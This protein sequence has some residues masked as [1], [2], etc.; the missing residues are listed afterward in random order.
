MEWLVVLAIFSLVWVLG[1]YF[2]ISRKRISAGGHRYH[3]TPIVPIVL[4]FMFFWATVPG[5][6]FS[7][8]DIF[9]GGGSSG[10]T[11]GE[12]ECPI[13]LTVGG[14]KA[15]KQEPDKYYKFLLSASQDISIDITNHD[16]PGILTDAHDLTIKLH[17]MNGDG[18]CKTSETIDQKT[19]KAEN[20]SL[21]HSALSGGKFYCIEMD[22]YSGGTVRPADQF[23]IQVNG[24]AAL[25]IG[26]SDASAREDES[27]LKFVV[28]MTKASGMNV[29]FQ[30]HFEDETAVAGINYDPKAIGQSHDCTQDNPCT[31][32]IPAGEL[33]TEIE[34]PLFD[35][36]MKTS[37]TFKM[38][39]DSADVDISGDDATATG[40]I[41]GSE[42]ESG[43]DDEC[44]ENGKPCICYDS[45]E[46]SGFCMFG[47]CIFYKEQTNI[48]ALGN[49]ED[50][51][52]I[53]A[54]TRGWAFMDFLSQ[55][56]INGERK[57]IRV[58]SDQAEKRTLFDK[59]N[60][61]TDG[62]VDFID[63][64]YFLASF[65]PTGIIYRLGEGADNSDGGS[66]NAG[67]TTSYYDKSFM[68]LGLFTAYTHIVSYTKNGKTYQS[69][70][71]P[72]N[73]DTRQLPPHPEPNQCGIFLGPLNSHNKVVFKS[74][75]WQE[76]QASMLNTP[77]VEDTQNTS[78]CNGVTPCPADG[79]GSSEMDLPEFLISQSGE[80]ITIPTSTVIGG[81]IDIGAINITH[82]DD[83]NST[84]RHFVFEAPY[85]DSYGGKV[86]LI[87][88]IEDKDEQ[89]AKHVYVFK[90]GDYWI[91]DWQILG[92][93]SVTIKVPDKN[94]RVRLFIK[95]SM[96]IDITGALNIGQEADETRSPTAETTK[97]FVYLYDNLTMMAHGSKALYYTFIYSK[98]NI[99]IGIP[100]EMEDGDGSI[101]TKYSA[102]T[103]DGQLSIGVDGAGTYTPVPDTL[104]FSDLFEKC[105]E[106]GNYLTGPFD[107]WDTFRDD[108]SAPPSDRNISTKIV[109]KDFKISVAS[110]NKNNDAYKTKMGSAG[111]VEVG[112]YAN[113]S[114]T[115]EGSTFPFDA[116][117]TPHISNFPTVGGFNV[118]R[119]IKNVRVGFKLCASYDYNSTIGDKIYY[120]YPK[121][122]CMGVIHDCNFTSAGPVW[123]I[124]YAGDNFAIRPDK[125]DSNL[126]NSGF[127][128]E[129]NISIIFKALD[130]NIT[131]TKPTKN[132]NETQG[133]TFVVDFNLSDPSLDCQQKINQLTPNIIFSDGQVE[134][135]YRFKYI[136]DYNLTIREKSECNQ[137]FAAVDCDD[138][139]ISGHW[140]TD[141]NLSIEPFRLNHISIKP[142]RFVIT[143]IAYTDYDVTNHFTYISNLNESDTMAAI[144]R[145]NLDVA[146]DNG[147]TAKNY[148]D[149]CYAKDFNTTLAFVKSKSNDL[150]LQMFN[151]L[152]N[153][154]SIGNHR[155]FNASYFPKSGYGTTT[156]T[157]FINFD[158]NASKPIDVFEHN[159]TLIKIEDDNGLS[160]EASTHQSTHFYYGRL[161][162]PD[163]KTY[164]NSIVTPIYAEIYSTTSPG[165][166]WNE[167]VDDINWWINP[168]HQ[169]SDGN[170]T[171]LMPKIGFSNQDDI[172]ITPTI[173]N[174]S[175]GISNPSITYNGSDRPHK[176]QIRIGT[177]PWLR[178]HRFITD[179]NKML[180][181]N[182]EFLGRGGW[183]GVGQKGQTLPDINGTNERIEW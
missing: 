30:Y 64:S 171:A 89:S 80:D 38:I 183:A 155:D 134:G 59:Y 28:A 7:F 138:A 101:A 45:R 103:A 142:A 72:C 176:T 104:R 29:N 151:D 69:V 146:K 67:D 136:G 5:Y 141:E 93:K 164:D 147:D 161:H 114:T 35:T 3:L 117:A 180:Y 110:L 4:V 47:S 43:S 130:G 167:S 10:C 70:L 53:K 112:I 26:V 13:E 12:A 6:A 75:S 65:L 20:F 46:T 74:R 42:S 129:R 57:T 106:S 140:N 126:T 34:V 111:S 175:H 22:G 44:G 109:G 41:I 39:I 36:H 150:T 168:L 24:S 166:D 23:D 157:L 131:S 81:Q 178:Y 163:Y 162:A 55:I 156:L 113:G 90:D 123:R 128:A 8:G 84:I 98:D 182:V 148:T 62:Q 56:G 71:Q 152:N 50:V 31:G 78:R 179:V 92:D 100:G 153:T 160:G 9:G 165:D 170:I 145:F 11:S 149:G 63:N 91:E 15:T 21:T 121:S 115:P 58:D 127:V 124:C 105:E 1:R 17:P 116:N 119:A 73:A 66:L 2:F 154:V 120:I 14:D 32:T 49:V 52:V 87:K 86:M 174:F 137:K 122:G 88:K 54:L 16:N 95:N 33:A 181:Y 40:T 77:E 135:N 85:S 19:S 118:S 102:I 18:S 158:R 25:E 108:S 172:K 61:P 169:N 79:I 143:N 37:K 68:K 82:S 76:V 125:F 97:L 27:P 107:A 48:R 177:Q 139:N 99:T 133:S 173:S 96:K 132:Y 94:A 51:K 60:A 83:T 144:L 159:I